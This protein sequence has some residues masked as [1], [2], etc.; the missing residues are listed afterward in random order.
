MDGWMDGWVDG[1]VDACMHDGEGREGGRNEGAGYADGGEEWRVEGEE[2]GPMDDGEEEGPTAD[3]EACR[4]LPVVLPAHGHIDRRRTFPSTRR[5]CSL[6]ARRTHPTPSLRPISLS[7]SVPMP[8][9]AIARLV[10]L[11]GSGIGSFPGSR[12]QV[13]R[14]GVRSEPRKWNT[15]V[16]SSPPRL[17]FLPPSR[18]PPSLT[19][20]VIY[21]F[22]DRS[23]KSF[24]LY[25]CVSYPS[26]IDP[27]SRP[28]P[29]T[30]SLRTTV[31][32]N[33]FPRST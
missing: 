18:T 13:V 30:F 31:F 20:C 11:A 14:A 7:G 17:P 15:R 33:F 2:E 23:H 32:L 21:A 8:A 10:V 25:F 4:S 27:V 19:A 9:T 28:K 26:T 12:A 3:G 22:N 16:A 29:D 5:R 24:G 6:Q 1:W